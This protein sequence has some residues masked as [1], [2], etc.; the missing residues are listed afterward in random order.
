MP[1]S[2]ILKPNYFSFTIQIKIQC[3][4]SF[5]G[6]FENNLGPWGDDR[7]FHVYVLSGIRP[8]IKIVKSLDHPALEKLLN[9]LS[10]LKNVPCPTN[11][12]QDQN[13][14]KQD[15]LKIKKIY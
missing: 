13:L 3:S 11:K 7:E 4:I 2:H 8:T 15:Q 9:E 10:V 14:F 5:G 1:L 12:A 6:I